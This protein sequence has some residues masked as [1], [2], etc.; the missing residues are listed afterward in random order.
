MLVNIADPANL[1]G[2]TLTLTRLDGVR[3]G[4][5]GEAVG[6]EIAVDEVGIGAALQR[7]VAAVAR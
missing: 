4:A 2:R 3:A 6:A 5:A 1:W 7:V